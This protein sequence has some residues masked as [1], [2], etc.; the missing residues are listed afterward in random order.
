MKN[1]S[2]AVVPL[3]LKYLIRW[4]IQ[5]T[6]HMATEAREESTNRTCN[7]IGQHIVQEFKSDRQVN[8]S[9]KDPSALFRSI[10][11]TPLA[12]G[13]SLYSYHNH[14]KKNEINF[15]N[16]YGIGISYGHM[17]DITKKIASNV[18]SNMLKNGGVFV[19]SGLLKI[20]LSN[21]HWIIL[22]LKLIHQ[23][24]IIHFMAQP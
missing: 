17:K 2:G 18:Q 11:N 8:L 22:M 3:E 23:M 21:V 13:L 19:P 9:P 15:W 16:S 6:S 20:S 1:D 10:H 4:I 5:G 12:V 24:G 7:I 14:H